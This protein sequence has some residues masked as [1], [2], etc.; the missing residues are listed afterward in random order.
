[1][2]PMGAL[3]RQSGPTPAPVALDARQQRFTVR[4]ASTCEGSKL[5]AVHDHPTFCAPICRD[6][7]KEH[8]RGREAETMHWPNPDEELGVQTVTLTEY[9][10]AKREAIHW[11]REREA[12]VGAGVW[13]RWTDGSQSDDGRVGAAAVCKHKDRWEAFRS[14]LG[15]GQ[16]EVYYAELRAIRLALWDS[17]R[18]RDTLQTFFSDAQAAI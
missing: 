15:T 6:I 10:A 8:K 17:E 1:M 2:T 13:M 12:K 3:M 4:L 16:M 5:K 11:A 7:T 18:T 9:T 14:H